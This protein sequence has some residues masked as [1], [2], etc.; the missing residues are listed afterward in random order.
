MAGATTAP[1]RAS[2]QLARVGAPAVGSALARAAEQFFP[3]GLGESKLGETRSG[4]S[5][6]WSPYRSSFMRLM[7]LFLLL[8]ERG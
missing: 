8:G 4:E 5:P 3:H 6:Y 2:V 1:T 7:R